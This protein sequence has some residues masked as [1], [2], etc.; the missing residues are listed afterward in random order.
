[1][2]ENELYLKFEKLENNYIEIGKEF[3]TMFKL[4]K[5]DFGNLVKMA[6]VFYDLSLNYLKENK[7]LSNLY[8]N[9][10][11][12]INEHIIMNYSREDLNYYFNKVGWE[13]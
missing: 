4:Y 9:Y 1:M 2:E 13:E 11:E 6:I 7:R 5:N 12:K 8:N 3:K 10:F